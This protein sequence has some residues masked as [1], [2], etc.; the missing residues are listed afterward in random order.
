MSPTHAPR[1]K[2]RRGLRASY[3]RRRHL[4]L[5]YQQLNSFQ[6]HFSALSWSA[7]SGVALGV[8]TT[9]VCLAVPN[10]I[11]VRHEGVFHMHVAVQPRYGGARDAIAGRGPVFL[12]LLPASG[13]RDIFTS[14]KM[15][16]T[17]VCRLLLAADEGSGRNLL[18][19]CKTAVRPNRVMRESEQLPS[20]LPSPCKLFLRC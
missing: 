9:A 3:A 6:F 13:V 2:H 20:L 19:C 7:L 5:G 12:R 4:C 17:A 11:K 15:Q 18:H 1:A 10:T 16:Y 8:S 14:S